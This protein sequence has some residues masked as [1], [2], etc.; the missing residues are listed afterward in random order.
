MNLQNRCFEGWLKFLDRRE[1]DRGLC[2]KFMNWV[3]TSKERAGFRK[4]RDTTREMARLIAEQDMDALR[5][6]LLESEQQRQELELIKEHAN[7]VARRRAK[8]MFATCLSSSLQYSFHSWKTT[9]QKIKHE[10]RA[11]EKVA[12]IMFAGSLRRNFG[13]WKEYTLTQ[14]KNKHL[15]ARFV[16]ILASRT[17]VAM[18]NTWKGFTA[19]SKHERYIVSK[20]K[21]LMKNGTVTLHTILRYPSISVNPSLG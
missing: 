7:D 15:L 14:L 10:K 20:F 8:V 11:I 1:H 2:D 5:L 3:C 17:M 6:Q 4:W 19:R 16:G 12:R 21:A 18:M 13:M 9:V